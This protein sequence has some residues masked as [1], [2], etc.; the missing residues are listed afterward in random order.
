MFV[1]TALLWLIR[2]RRIEMMDQTDNAVSQSNRLSGLSEYDRQ[3]QNA[4]VESKGH[5]HE[6][7]S[8]WR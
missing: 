4:E 2:D 1:T 3:V 6:D 7:R 8:N 5:N